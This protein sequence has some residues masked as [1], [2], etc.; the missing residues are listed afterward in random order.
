LGVLPRQEWVGEPLERVRAEPR[1][2]EREGVQ[3]RLQAGERRRRHR[4][5][6]PRCRLQ[7]LRGRDALE[8]LPAT[9]AHVGDA[10]DDLASGMLVLAETVAESAGL[11]TSLDFDHLPPEERALSWH[12]HELAARLRAAR[13]SV[14][15]ARG[16]ARELGQSGSARAGARGRA[17]WIGPLRAG[18]GHGRLRLGQASMRPRRIA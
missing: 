8:N 15:T 2:G 13:A 18:A 6:R 17:L 10:V 3:R 7:R 14:E 4:A 9:L 12:L 1:V 16:W 5:G 11:G